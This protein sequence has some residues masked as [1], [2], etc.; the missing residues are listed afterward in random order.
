MIF[1]GWLLLCLCA[2]KEQWVLFVL[3]LLDEWELLALGRVDLPS[4]WLS[5]T[6]EVLPVAHS[7][8][9]DWAACVLLVTTAWSDPLLAVLCI[10]L[11]T[12]MLCTQVMRTNTKLGPK[13]N[14]ANGKIITKVWE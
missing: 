3:V 12:Q 14:D 7:Q 6:A 13:L 8:F 9:S 1:A 4:C 2:V 5:W 10:L 11:G